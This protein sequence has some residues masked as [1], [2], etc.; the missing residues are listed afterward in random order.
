TDSQ[1][2]LRRLFGDSGL[3]FAV[4]R[5]GELTDWFRLESS[6]G[7]NLRRR[8]RSLSGGSASTVLSTTAPP[9]RCRFGGRRAPRTDLGSHRCS[10]GFR[11]HDWTAPS[12][13]PELRADG[14]HPQSESGGW[15]L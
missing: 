1:F 13:S 3:F 10:P 15:R 5:G 12:G 8:V 7:R 9:L 4:L 14:R 2:R 11:Q 6:L